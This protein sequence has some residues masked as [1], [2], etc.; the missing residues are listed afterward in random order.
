[1]RVEI[2]NVG[3]GSAALVIGDNR[4]IALFD[5][6][7]DEAGFRPSRYLPA[8]W[9]AIQALTVSHYD[10]DH[11]SD[12]AELRALMP[13]EVLYSNPTISVQQIR[14]LKEQEGTLTAGI[15]ALLDM[16]NSFGPPGSGSPPDLAGVQLTR[17]FHSYERFQDMN[18]LSI[19][20]FVEFDGFS[21][22]FPG[23]LERAGW[24][25]HLQN[26]AFRQALARTQYFVASHH[27]RDNGYCEGVFDWCSPELVII[28]DTAM[29]YDTQEHC[30]ASYASGTQF[31]RN[32]QSLGTR[33][34]LTT[35]CDGH[36]VLEKTRSQP[37]GI[38]YGPNILA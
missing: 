11:V 37:L 14:R 2:F 28:S 15:E 18:N 3:H 23:D 1:M 4:N 35:R 33:F 7:H 19:V 21:I 27:G 5:C 34:V 16:K 30:Y 13:I 10:S 22:V 20:T 6:G 24:L 29:Q 38:C 31:Y 17:F 26:Q 9:R 8:R 25:A 32:G 36:I 12:L